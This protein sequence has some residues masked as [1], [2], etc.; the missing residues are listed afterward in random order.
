[1]FIETTGIYFNLIEG[2]K[3]KEVLQGEESYE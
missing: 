1:M 2:R 3:D